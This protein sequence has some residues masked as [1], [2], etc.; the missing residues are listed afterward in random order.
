[1]VIVFDLD[2]TL[3]LERDYQISG[4]KEVDNC[5]SSE[6]NIKGFYE[7]AI[8][9]LESG[10]RNII[11]VALENFFLRG[12]KKFT[13]FQKS[14]LT[15]YQ[16]HV[17][18]ISL[19]NDALFILNKLKITNT[20]L[21]LITDGRPNG[22]WNKVNSLGL[23]EFFPKIVV[24]GDWGEEY[25]KPNHRAYREVMNF[26]AGETEFIYIADNPK[27]DF[28]APQQLGWLPSIRVRRKQGLHYDHDGDDLTTMKDLCGVFSFLEK[29]LAKDLLKM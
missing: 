16:E 9:A 11:D 1:M 25:F 8:A 7:F 20:K 23:Q 10:K 22:Q 26:Y 19:L 12:S 2:D 18:N 28:I 14:S 6:H 17:P 21:A 24:T 27:K 13:D 4:L 15:I 3:I 29:M 5:L